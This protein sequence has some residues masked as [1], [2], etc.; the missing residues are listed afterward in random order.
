MQ[1]E[2]AADGRQREESLKSMLRAA[3]GSLGELRR[4]YEVREARWREEER[5]RE[6]NK[7]RRFEVPKWPEKGLVCKNQSG[8]W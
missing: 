2:A 5:K 4:M 8:V 6:K 1:E 7:M 3:L